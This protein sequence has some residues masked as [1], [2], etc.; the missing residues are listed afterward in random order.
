MEA[1]AEHRRR[2]SEQQPLETSLSP[3]AQLSPEG[4]VD[5]SKVFVN[6]HR[7]KTANVRGRGASSSHYS[8]VMFHSNNEDYEEQELQRK[9]D[10]YENMLHRA[11]CLR[12]MKLDESIDKA[13]RNNQLM[14]HKQ[15]VK[16]ERLKKNEYDR[17]NELITNFLQQ[18]KADK[19][20]EK[21]DNDLKEHKQ[22]KQLEKIEFKKAKLQ[23]I[24][25][26]FAERLNLIEKKRLD[27]ES[28]IH[29][30][31]SAFGEFNSQKKEIN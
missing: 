5:V 22:I 3:K 31:K 4:A 30:I 29:N 9:L 7:A 6:Q 21:R 24:H 20:K 27:K 17:L 19:K 16:G 28:V 12:Q 13:H 26:Q 8:S 2:I 23:D 15:E 11:E 25:K 18:K 10:E 1:M 14:Y